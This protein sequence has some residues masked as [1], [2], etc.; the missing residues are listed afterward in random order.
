M[1]LLCY[2][3]RILISFPKICHSFDN[4][5]KIKLQPNYNHSFKIGCHS[6]S[7]NTHSFKIG[8]HSESNYNH[9]ISSFVLLS[10]SNHNHFL[11]K[12]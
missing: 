5:M 6:Q 12:T 7:N 4:H 11:L 1:R 10:Y 3:V 2:D 8:C 9:L